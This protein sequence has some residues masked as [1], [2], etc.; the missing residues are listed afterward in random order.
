MSKQQNPVTEQKQAEQQIPPA[1]QAMLEQMQKQM[2]Q[3]QSQLAEQ[4]QANAELQNRLAVAERKVP[5]KGYVHGETGRMQL[6]LPNTVRFEPITQDGQIVGYNAPI[7]I[8]A[9]KNSSNEVTL[10]AEQHTAL[11]NLC[12]KLGIEVG[13]QE[14]LLSLS[15]ALPSWVPKKT[16]AQAASNTIVK[17]LQRS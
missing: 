17:G 10:T 13:S 2:E 12:I 11:V 4:K 3:M 8:L 7:F 9:D 1:M 14:S 15:K 16:Q 5:Y 6:T